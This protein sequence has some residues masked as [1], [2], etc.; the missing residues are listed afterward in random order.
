MNLAPKER[1]IPFTAPMVRAL[2]A[3]SKTQTRR[4]IKPHRSDDAFALLDHGDGWWPYRSEDGESANVDNMEYPLNSPYG[5]AGDRLWVRET[6]RP[7][8]GQSCGLIGVDYQAD[9]REKWARLGDEIGAPVKWIPPMFMRRE[10]SR[11]LLEV[12]SVRAE[13]LQ[14]IREADA[15]AEGIHKQPAGWHS[16]PGI[17][18]SGTTARAAYA[19][20][21]NHIHGA[22]SW[23]ANPWVWVVTF[24]PGMGPARGRD[25]A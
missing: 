21:W 17:N 24:K 18:G 1:P 5:Q 4:L 16:V 20:L 8:F 7:I 22:G 6:H 23:D 25:G 10:Y 15:I 12:A 2:L 13:R 9:P 11:L 3:G 14:D 19:M